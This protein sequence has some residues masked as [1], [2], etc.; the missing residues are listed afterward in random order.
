LVFNLAS[1]VPSVHLDSILY[2]ENIVRITGITRR[3]NV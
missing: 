2:H 3:R 1:A